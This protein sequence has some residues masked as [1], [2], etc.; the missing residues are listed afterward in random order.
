MT[1][2]A[3]TVAGAEPDNAAKKGTGQHHCKG[4]SSAKASDDAIGKLYKTPGNSA[5][6]H[7]ISGQDKECDSHYGGGIKSAENSLCN[8]A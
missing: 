4:H 6:C 5:L 1:P 2:I 7:D 3:T 8:D